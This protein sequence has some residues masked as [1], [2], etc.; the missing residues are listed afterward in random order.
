MFS[1]GLG[2]ADC[3]A[4]GVLVLVPAHQ[5]AGLGH[6]ATV[7]RSRLGVPGIVLAHWSVEL[8]PRVAECW[9]GGPGA[10]VGLLMGG[11]VAQ[12][13]PGAGVGRWWVGLLLDMAG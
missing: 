13:C 1:L 9:A 12:E 2:M 7:Y 8:G 10:S 11:A 3:T 5:W 6:E 4:R